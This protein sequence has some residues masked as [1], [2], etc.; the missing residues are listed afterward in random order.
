[1][2]IASEK[3]I[4]AGD[5]S[6]AS[7]TS[8]QI[9]LQHIYFVAIQVIVPTATAVGTLDFQYSLDGINWATKDSTAVSLSGA[10]LNVVK[11]FANVC[12]PYARAVYTK[13]SGTGDITVLIN[14]KGF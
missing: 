11:E 4:D 9:S 3:L 14:I 12:A 13:T 2:R 1:M 5:M 8:E 6:L 10:A 7:V